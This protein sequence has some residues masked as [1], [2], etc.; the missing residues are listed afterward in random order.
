MESAHIANQ[1]LLND[2]LHF[3]VDLIGL[4][5]ITARLIIVWRKCFFVD[6]IKIN[7]NVGY[8]IDVFKVRKRVTPCLTAQT[9]LT[10]CLARGVIYVGVALVGSGAT[11]GA[12]ELL[13][14]LKFL[15]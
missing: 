5:Q 7:L 3:L 11:F 15:L 14:W 8:V 4:I 9:K 1:L 6:L 13:G 2:F 12:E 10:R